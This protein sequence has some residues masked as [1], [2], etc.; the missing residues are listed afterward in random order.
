MGRILKM[1]IVITFKE[2]PK[3]FAKAYAEFLKRKEK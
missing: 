2:D 1:T 3:A